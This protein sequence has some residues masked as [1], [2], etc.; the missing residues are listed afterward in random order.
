[1]SQ[2]LM[3]ALVA[4]SGIAFSQTPLSLQDAVRKAQLQRP[5]LRAA[6]ERAGAAEQL[7]RQAALLP[8]PRLFLQSENVRGS[9]FDYGRDADT[10]VYFS[11]VLETSGRRKGRIEVASGDAERRRLEEEK[12]KREIGFTVR[13]AYWNALAAQFTLELFEQNES[14]FR[15]VVDY[16][17][18]R[19]HEGK[20]AEVDMLRI[21]LQAAQIHAAARSVTLRSERAQ[22][23]LARAMGTPQMGPWQLTERFDALE[24]PRTAD[25]GGDPFA[26]RPEGR[27]AQQA[28]A[29]ARANLSL[30]RARGRPDLDALFGYKRT[31]GLNTAIAGLQLNLPLFDRNQGASSA[32]QSEI[33]AAESDLQ[34]LRFRLNLERSLTRRT[35]DLRLEELNAT[36]GPMRERAIEIA[37]ISR[38]AYKEGGLDLLRLL[39]AEKLRVDAQLTWVE[40]LNQY[41]EAVVEL[42]RAE[43]VEP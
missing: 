8:N 41:H 16:H 34:A 14:Y 2:R 6:A 11:Q 22:V 7:R 35:Y 10:F 24:P 25:A 4:L 18:A 28:V 43:G 21:Q 31:S 19:L 3:C 1:M 36:F 12:L 38:A 23:E 40:A 20:L 5:E 39:D 13:A 30:E 42:E 9:N 32:A 26:L 33:N 29:T 37:D 27:L 15:Q 17:A